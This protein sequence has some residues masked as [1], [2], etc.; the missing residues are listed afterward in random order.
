MTTETIPLTEKLARALCEANGQDPDHDYDPNMIRAQA[1][2]LRWKLYVN[3]ARAVLQT[4]HD[5]ITPEMVEAG[6]A[7]IERAETNETDPGEEGYF[8]GCIWSPSAIDGF[9][10]MI[11]EALGQ[12]TAL[13]GERA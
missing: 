11:A 10:A 6:C 8:W 1:P 2:D 4:L 3:Q 12:S 13:K 7:A 9:Q 5:N